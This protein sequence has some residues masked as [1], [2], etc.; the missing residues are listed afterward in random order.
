MVLEALL[1]SWT[2]ISRENSYDTTRHGFNDTTYVFA[3]NVVLLLLNSYNG[4]GAA[5]RTRVP[6]R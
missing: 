5:R 4:F 1:T 6:L 2:T 3:T